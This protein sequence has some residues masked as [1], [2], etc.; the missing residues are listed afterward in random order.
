MHIIKTDI[1]D[2]LIIE[3]KVF[4]DSRGFFYESYNKRDFNSA[5]ITYDFVQDNH[6]LST[7]GV[8]RGLHYQIK[9]P[10]GKLIRA[11]SG[12][13]FDAVVDLRKGSST[14]GK[15]VCLTLSAENKRMIWM[16]PGF[17]HGFLVMS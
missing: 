14:F 15:S 12:E 10:Q 1:Q 16:P 8:L 17:A 5:G 7:K 9:N 13:I 3:P 2:V 4:N 11:L 6:S